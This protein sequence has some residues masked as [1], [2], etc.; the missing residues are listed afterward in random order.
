MPRRPYAVTF[1]ISSEGEQQELMTYVRLIKKHKIAYELTDA[2]EGTIAMWTKKAFEKTP[3]GVRMLFQKR[4]CRHRRG[5]LRDLC[6]RSH[7]SA[8]GLS[9]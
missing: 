2:D 3:N 5:S 4:R 7:L 1:E 9:A 6:R 8:A